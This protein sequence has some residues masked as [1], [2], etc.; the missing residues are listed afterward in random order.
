[1]SATIFL[2][3]QILVQFLYAGFDTFYIFYRKVYISIIAANFPHFVFP[4]F[5][6]WCV[7]RKKVCCFDILKNHATTFKSSFF[8]AANFLSVKLKCVFSSC[9]CALSSCIDNSKAAILLAVA[10]HL[11]FVC[12]KN[13]FN[14]GDIVFRFCLTKI[15]YKKL[16]R[17]RKLLTFDL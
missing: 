1:M 5:N 15:G 8:L 14:S 17:N 12:S 6:F 9:W 10:S 4:V 2:R 11:A 7:F 3:Y 13:F 16:L